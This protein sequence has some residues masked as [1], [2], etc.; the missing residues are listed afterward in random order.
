VR[1]YRQQIIQGRLQLSLQD[2]PAPEPGPGQLLVRVRAAGLNRGEFIAGHG[3]HG[4]GGAAKPV[5]MEAAGEVVA[6]GPDAGDWRPGDRVMGRCP[7]AFAELALMDVREAMPLPAALDWTQAAAI[8]L[9]FLVVY[10]MLVLQGH[11]RVGETLL[12]AGVS[13]GVGVGGGGG[14]P[15]PGGGGAAPTSWSDWPSRAWTWPCTP[16]PR[17]FTMP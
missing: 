4:A 7:G 13:S 5:G 11:L 10:D 1:A 15:P 3:L 17:T 16:A 12:V 2:L 14:P 9:T 8:P 6:L